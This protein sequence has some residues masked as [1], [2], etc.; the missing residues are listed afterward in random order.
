MLEFRGRFLNSRV[1]FVQYALISQT[2]LTWWR[3]FAA[4]PSSHQLPQLFAASAPCG[5]QRWFGSPPRVRLESLWYGFDVALRRMKRSNII[6]PF[7][8]SHAPTACRH[9]LRT[10]PCEEPPTSPSWQSVYEMASRPHRRSR[11]R[12]RR[13]VSKSP[14]SDQRLAVFEPVSRPPL[15]VRLVLRRRRFA[16]RTEVPVP[17]RAGRRFRRAS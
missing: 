13:P 2:E 10:W 5:G 16:S 7:Q 12:T 17:H 11:S 1:Q 6:E 14:E 9:G 15:R 8:I 3:A 4:I